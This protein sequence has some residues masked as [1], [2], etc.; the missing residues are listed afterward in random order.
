MNLLNRKTVLAFFISFVVFSVA[1]LVVAA[2]LSIGRGG[3]SL[4]RKV[5][6]T[7][8]ESFNILLVMTDYSPERFDDY[9]ADSIEN[10]FETV[11]LNTGTRKIRAESM[12]LARFDS[13]RSE[14]TLTPISGNTIVTVRGKETTLD[15]VASDCGSVILAE[16]VRAMTGLE[17]DSYIVFTPESASEALDMLGSFKYKISGD[18]VWQDSALGID[19]NIK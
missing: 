3:I 15:S 19:I 16:K 14:L 1:A 9:D 18:L 8:G 6:S 2:L 17:I 10:V 11:S 4:P 12:L 7:D 13:K 5:K